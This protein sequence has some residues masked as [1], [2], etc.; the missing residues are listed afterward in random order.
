M[1]VNANKVWFLCA[2]IICRYNWIYVDVG[3]SLCEC[4][5]VWMYAG[6]CNY[7]LLYV[8]KCKHVKVYVN[9]CNY[10]K[11]Y[12]NTYRY[13]L[14]N[15]GTCEIVQIYIG[16]CIWYLLTCVN[17]CKYVKVFVK[18]ENVCRNISD[19]STMVFQRVQSTLD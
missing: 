15:V 12:V 19:G 6:L 10:V 2:L 9:K 3:M 13:V 17:K 16:A 11:V 14:M 1:F 18:N 5:Y 8:N 4:W 7:V